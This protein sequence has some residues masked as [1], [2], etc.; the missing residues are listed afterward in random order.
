MAPTSIPCRFN[1]HN[2]H[3]HTSDGHVTFYGLEFGTITDA[4]KLLS[5]VRPDDYQGVCFGRNGFAKGLVRPTD[6]RVMV[7]VP[8]YTGKK[9]FMNLE[10]AEHIMGP[11]F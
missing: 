3:T 6:G 7:S 11:R 8:P 1:G 4:V 5:R 10:R 2:G 9:V